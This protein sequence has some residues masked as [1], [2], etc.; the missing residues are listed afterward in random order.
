MDFRNRW[1]KFNEGNHI[2]VIKCNLMVVDIYRC[3]VTNQL[4]Q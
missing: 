4:I 2:R 1:N 3:S